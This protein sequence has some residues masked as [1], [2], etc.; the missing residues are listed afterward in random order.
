M[1]AALS[2]YTAFSIAPLLILVIAIAGL[3]FGRDAAQGRLFTEIAGLVG[4]QSAEAIQSMIKSA[5][6]PTHGIL[7]TILSLIGLLGG[8]SGVLSERSS[9]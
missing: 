1:S 9:P 7:A 4:P 6:K 2:Y 5:S 3:A 8:A